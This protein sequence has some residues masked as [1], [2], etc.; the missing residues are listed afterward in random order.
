MVER[1]VLKQTL[2][3]VVMLL[4]G[5]YLIILVMILAL[6]IPMTV[7]A[8]KSLLAPSLVDRDWL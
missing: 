7:W 1:T 5:V 4:T 3:C 8:G 2:C 6:V